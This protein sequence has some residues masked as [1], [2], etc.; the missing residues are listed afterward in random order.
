MSWRESAHP[1][2]HLLSA[3]YVPGIEIEPGLVPILKHHVV[4]I[5]LSSCGLIRPGPY[6][7]FF[8]LAD[9]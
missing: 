8:C 9:V 4:L 1:T 6:V 7:S 5:S 3:R 2:K